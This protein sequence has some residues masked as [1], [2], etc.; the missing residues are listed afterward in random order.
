MKMDT[1]FMEPDEA[2]A[3]GREPM[4]RDR[5]TL[6]R[7]DIPADTVDLITGLLAGFRLAGRF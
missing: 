3:R 7:A 1:P 4:D 6:E 5:E 2:G